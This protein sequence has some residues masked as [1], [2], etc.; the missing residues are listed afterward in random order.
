MDHNENKLKTKQTDGT[1]LTSSQAKLVNDR[2][3]ATRNTSSRI[4]FSRRSRL[5][6]FSHVNT[7]HLPESVGY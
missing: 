7:I 1:D 6:V 4:V 5:L 3:R 2:T